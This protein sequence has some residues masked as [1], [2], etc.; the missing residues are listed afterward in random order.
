M[1]M[2]LKALTKLKRLD[3]ENTQVTD[4]GLVHLKG[5]TNLKRLYLDNT[6]VTDE[7]VKKLQQV[8]P[9]CRIIYLPQP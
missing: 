7:G 4:A 8:L 5:M 1:V 2:H 3:L 9:N 6:Q